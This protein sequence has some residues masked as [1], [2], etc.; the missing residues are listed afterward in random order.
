MVQNG[1]GD[2]AAMIVPSD[3]TFLAGSF[4]VVQLSSGDPIT[5]KGAN[6]VSLIH[7]GYGVA[8]DSYDLDRLGTS[9]ALVKLSGANWMYIPVCGKVGTNLIE[10]GTVTYAKTSGVQKEAK[11]IKNIGL[12]TLSWV[13]DSTT[14]NY[15]YT[16]VRTDS[17]G[18]IDLSRAILKP[19]VDGGNSYIYN[20]PMAEDCVVRAVEAKNGTIKF[21]AKKLPSRKLWFELIVL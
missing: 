3:S 12:D 18:A 5:I 17:V 21:F 10:D 20:Y 15:S 6:G 11:V 8:A 9:A 16:F 14:G 19:Y 1:A 4:I 2:G 7:A 13:H